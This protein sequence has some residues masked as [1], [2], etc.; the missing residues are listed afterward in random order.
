[1]ADSESRTQRAAALEEK[2]RRLE[3]L[4]QRRSRRGEDTA[5]VRAS[6]S[7]NLDEYIDGL[8]SQ[9]S[10]ESVRLTESDAD[11][12]AELV[13]STQNGTVA[14][15]VST[16]SASS[17]TTT[18]NNVFA[19]PAPAPLPKTVETFTIGTQTDTDIDDSPDAVASEENKPD[20]TERLLGDKDAA[21]ND[22]SKDQHNQ[23]PKMLSP[24]DLEKE[25]ASKPFSNFL[26]SASKKVER[27]LGA[28]LLTD[29]FADYVGESHDLEH[30]E[31]VSKETDQS[32]FLASRQVYECVKW[33]SGRDVTDMDWSP[34]HRELLLSTYHM[35]MSTSASAHL[36]KG[37][38]AVSAVSPNDTLSSSLTPRSGELQSDGLAL[39]WNLTMPSRPEHVFTC[40]SPVTTG[41]FHPSESPL[42]VGGCESGQMVVWDV[43]AGR[44]PVQKSAL[45]SIAGASS[46]GHVHPICRMEVVEGG[47]RETYKPVELFVFRSVLTYITLINSVSLE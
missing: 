23:I 28:P 43:R 35:C 31:S 13:P 34:L 41:R 32:K 29:L 42:I 40:G 47:V 7:A 19:E 5:N 3:E 15:I 11:T 16:K 9:P 36:S 18:T 2:R 27:L 44:L 4:K 14:A 26:N 25:I 38:A 17:S 45:S 20:L 22:P 21:E 12:V 30:T 1:M 46:K 6:A 8:L 39:V 10:T 24:E 37:S 33:T